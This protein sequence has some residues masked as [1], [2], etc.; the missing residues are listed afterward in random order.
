V[1]PKQL[2]FSDFFEQLNT[3]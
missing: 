3:E 1:S 2:K